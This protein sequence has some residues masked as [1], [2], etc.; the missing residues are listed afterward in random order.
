[1]QNRWGLS[2]HASAVKPPSS[3]SGDALLPPPFPPDPP[4][5]TS[6]SPLLF[7]PLSSTPP[8]SRSEIRRSHLSSPPSDTVMAQALDLSP[9]VVIPGNTT[10][11]GSLA[12]IAKQVTVA[13]GNP[14]PTTSSFVTATSS[15]AVEQVPLR[16]TDLESNKLK[17]LPPNH[18]SPMLTNLASQIHSHNLSATPTSPPLVIPSLP[19]PIHPTAPPIIQSQVPPPPSSSQ[20]TLADKL[21]VKGDKSLRRLAP[22][23]LS[24]SGRPRV[25]IP[26]SVFQKGA[27]LHKDFIVC[28]FNGRPPPFLQI[29][30]VLNH[31]WGK[32][33]RLE[34]H[35]NPLQRSAL[36]RIPS[37]FLRQKILDKNI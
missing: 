21:R 3:S 13:T 1:M 17:V 6:L 29:Q 18:N 14:Y 22:A 15:S 34:I 10:Q 11:F 7:P 31:M 28:Y 20:P 35:N 33:R 24:E 16:T 32:G 27:E 5:P 25:L 36:V 26:D 8:M 2:G 30:N 19:P 4:D 9:A 37:E 23:T 12:E